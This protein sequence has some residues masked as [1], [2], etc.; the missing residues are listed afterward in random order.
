MAKNR[1][2]V[3]PGQIRASEP[4]RKLLIK[5]VFFSSL[6]TLSLYRVLSQPCFFLHHIA[7]PSPTQTTPF[8]RSVQQQQFLDWDEL[9]CAASGK[10]NSNC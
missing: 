2:P 5:E 1:S 7:S 10:Y 4:A 6:S 3:R 9:S 8:V